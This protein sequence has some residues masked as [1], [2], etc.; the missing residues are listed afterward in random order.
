MI[1]VVISLE[2]SCNDL[3]GSLMVISYGDL[4]MISV[5]SMI[6]ELLR[7]ARWEGSSIERF[8]LNLLEF[9]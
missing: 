6:Y 8:H 2:I 1:S 7:S 9:Y 3:L 4:F 5:I